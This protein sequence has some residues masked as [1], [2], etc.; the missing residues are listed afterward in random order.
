MKKSDC[1]K[2]APYAEGPETAV[3]MLVGQNPGREEVKQQRPFVGRS[4]QYLNRMLQKH[5]LDRGMMY[6][7]AA[8]KAPTP[9]NRKPTAAEIRYWQPCLEAE[10][11]RVKP[12]IVVLLGRVAAQA[13]RPAGIEYLETCHPAAAMRFPA[14]H[15]RFEEDMQTLR[16]M[17]KKYIDT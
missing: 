13:P 12:A 2:T 11:Q 8:V 15:R 10:I 5:R 17:I 7:T 4:G 1:P 3:V 6:V 9:R 16:Q 14:M